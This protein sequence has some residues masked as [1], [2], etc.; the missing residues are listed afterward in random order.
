MQVTSPGAAVAW[1]TPTIEPI[2]PSSVDAYDP[3]N[4]DNGG[5]LDSPPQQQDG[6]AGYDTVET[7]PL[8]LGPAPGFEILYTKPLL[9]DP[10]TGEGLELMHTKPLQISLDG[11]GPEAW[12]VNKPLQIDGAQGV[13]IAYTKP[14]LIDPATGEGQELLHTKPLQITPEHAAQQAATLGQLPLPPGIAAQVAPTQAT[15][16]DAATAVAAPKASAMEIAALELLLAEPANQE[17]IAQF[18]PPL[19]PLISRQRAPSRFA[20]LRFLLVGS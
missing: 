7:K 14:L 5:T 9:V 10:A 18:G 4:P 15:S 12:G 3:G 13:E 17:M 6:S 19:A 11:S 1:D 20:S 8:P 2:I 16:P